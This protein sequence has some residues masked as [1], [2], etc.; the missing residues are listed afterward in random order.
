MRTLRLS[1]P[2]HLCVP[3]L[4]PLAALALVVGCSN[5]EHKCLCDAAITKTGRAQRFQNQEPWFL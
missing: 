5:D 1:S 4:L 3:A 2:L